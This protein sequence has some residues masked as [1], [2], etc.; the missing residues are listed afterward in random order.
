M[1]SHRIFQFSPLREGRHIPFNLTIHVNQFQFSPL[2]EGRRANET[3]TIVQFISILAPARGATR[4]CACRIVRKTFQFSPLREG[5]RCSR[6]VT[7]RWKV[8]QFSPLREGRLD[9]KLYQ[10][11][12]KIFQF[13]PLREGRLYQVIDGLASMEI[14]ILAPARGAT[15][16]GIGRGESIRFQFSPL[17][18]GRHEIDV[19]AARGVLISILAPARGATPPKSNQEE[20]CN[21]SILA[22]ARGATFIG[23][24]SDHRVHFNSRPCERGD[25]H[26]YEAERQQKKFQFSPLREGRHGRWTADYINPGISILAPARGATPESLRNSLKEGFQFSPLREGRR[27]EDVCERS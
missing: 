12:R 22:P 14:S 10:E 25:L 7:R 1:H 8:F 9:R 11:F 24:A 13:S 21:I 16:T 17:R 4:S 3:V 19:L 18:E 23:R 2:R 5:R 15:H 27:T 6:R 26:G 20:H